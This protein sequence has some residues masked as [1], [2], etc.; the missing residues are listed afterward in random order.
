M[1]PVLD[2]DG[3]WVGV[4]AARSRSTFR[5]GLLGGGLSL[6]VRL[7]LGLVSLGFRLVLRLQSASHLQSWPAHLLGDLC[8][9]GLLLW[10]GSG[11]LPLALGRLLLAILLLL[12]LQ[13]VDIL[14]GLGFGLLLLAA[15]LLLGLVPL[16]GV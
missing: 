14:L 5:F 3:L 8:L 1:S 11:A 12:L 4:L 7:G 2:L 9:L 10:C 15:V 6:V 16:A 13:L